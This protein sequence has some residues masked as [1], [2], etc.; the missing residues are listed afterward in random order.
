MP[1]VQYLSSLPAGFDARARAA[2]ASIRRSACPVEHTGARPESG[3]PFLVDGGIKERLVTIGEDARTKK[4]PLLKE[5]PGSLSEVAHG[6][7][8]RK[9]TVE[10]L[11]KLAKAEGL[12]L[13]KAPSRERVVQELASLIAAGSEATP[14]CPGPA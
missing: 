11:R 13:G 1:S 5:A 2:Y 3:A 12:D 7:E 9:Y 10:A 4:G 8:L 6:E 14:A